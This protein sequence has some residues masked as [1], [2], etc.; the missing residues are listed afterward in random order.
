MPRMRNFN[1]I[2]TC[3]NQNSDQ[4]V[5]NDNVGVSN[6]FECSLHYLLSFQDHFSDSAVPA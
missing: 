1:S 3:C 2:L 5:C 6:T 4:G